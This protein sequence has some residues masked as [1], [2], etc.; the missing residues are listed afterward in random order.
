MAWIESHQTLLKHPKTLLLVG[1]LATDKYKVIGHLHAMWWW[2]L[3]LADAEG[4]LPP[5][6]SDAAIADGAGWPI[7]QAKAF[8]K[9]LRSA[10]FLEKK[11][12]VLHDW[13]DY[14]GYYYGGRRNASE[15]GVA[16]NHQRWHVNRGIVDSNCEFCRGESD[17]DPN[18]PAIPPDSDTESDRNPKGNRGESHLTLPPPLPTN[19][20]NLPTGSTATDRTA[21]TTKMPFTPDQIL[22][23]QR[24]HP[25]VN[26]NSRWREFVN[27]VNEEEEKRRPKDLFFAFDGWLKKKEPAFAR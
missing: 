1:Q 14:A 6:T 24:G 18:R 13:P 12:Y 4:N 3:D 8:V 26:T 22:Q 25:G 9:A 16:G 15:K 10:G 23:L 17:S 11:G 20:T 21:L 2:A 27:W 7:E 5:G 19:L